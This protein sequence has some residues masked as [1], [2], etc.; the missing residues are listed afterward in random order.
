M[1]AQTLW[2]TSNALIVF[3]L[4]RA[5]K[6]RF[7]TKYPVFYCYLGCVLL[8]SFTRLYADFF[9]PGSYT[10]FYW[11]TEFLS[12]AVGYCIIWELYSKS[13]HSYPGVV[14]ISGVPPFPET[15]S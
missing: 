14:Q 12:I 15:V 1:L 2:W 9:E 6:G 5:V 3:L 10:R 7:F 13:L 4:V 11:Y 8:A